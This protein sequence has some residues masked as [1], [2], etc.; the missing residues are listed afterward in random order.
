MAPPRAL[1]FAQDL[2]GQIL[3]LILLGSL[4]QNSTKNYTVMKS[5]PSWWEIM[6]I[7]S[8]DKTH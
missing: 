4:I 6:T 7:I 8:K 5:P 2:K 3:V 1:G